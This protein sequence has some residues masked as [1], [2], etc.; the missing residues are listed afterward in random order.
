MKNKNLAYVAA[1]LIKTA[2]PI[3]V[4]KIYH[5]GESKNQ[6]SYSTFWRNIIS[7]SIQFLE[8]EKVSGKNKGVKLIVKKI[9]KYELAKWMKANLE[10]D[11]QAD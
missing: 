5:N 3:E 7:L 9:K 10:K 1:D 11:S 6:M 4:S 2:T 8:L